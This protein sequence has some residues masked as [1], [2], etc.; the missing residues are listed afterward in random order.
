MRSPQPADMS[1]F[2]KYRRR[3]CA[4]WEVVQEGFCGDE[5]RGTCAWIWS[6]RCDQDLDEVLIPMMATF[7]GWTLLIIIFLG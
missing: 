5:A 2:L 7:L 1:I 3:E 4:F 6:V